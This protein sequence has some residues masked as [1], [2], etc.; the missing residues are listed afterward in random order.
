MFYIYQNSY[1]RYDIAVKTSA[2]PEK[3]LRLKVTFKGS[4]NTRQDMLD[5]AAKVGISV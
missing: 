3:S 1:G 2:K 5:W 4:E